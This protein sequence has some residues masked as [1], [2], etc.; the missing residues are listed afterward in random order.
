MKRPTLSD[1]L[2]DTHL[3]PSAGAHLARAV[4]LMGVRFPS[5]ASSIFIAAPPA[6]GAETVAVTTPPLT[7]PLDF[8]QVLLWWYVELVVGAGTTNCTQKLRRGASTASLLIITGAALTV[9]AGNTVGFTGLFVDN[10]GAVAGVQYSIAFLGT[11]TTGAWAQG[12]FSTMIAFA[13]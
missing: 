4:P 12:S 7:L 13:L 3:G 1:L 10:P 8:A 11:G 6:S 2:R 9:T 5:V